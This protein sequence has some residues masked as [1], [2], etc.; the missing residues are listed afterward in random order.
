VLNSKVGSP[1]DSK[2]LEIGE[3]GI[4]GG[5][6]NYLTVFYIIHL[7]YLGN[8]CRIAHITRLPS[9]KGI[10]YSRRSI[11]LAIGQLFTIEVYSECHKLPYR[12][13][14]VAVGEAIVDPLRLESCGELR[15]NQTF[16][17]GVITYFSH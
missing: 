12:C 5:I 16:S 15:V 10:S 9:N 11:Y 4:Q 6:T 8:L 14:I 1:R 3:I 13:R 7:Q 2:K 17:K